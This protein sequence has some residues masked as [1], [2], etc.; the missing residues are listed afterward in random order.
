[1]IAIVK[2]NAGNSTSVKNA[3]E[4]LGFTCTITNDHQALKNA[5]KVIFPGV[6]AA[7]RAMTY[8]KET[9]LD[10]LI[11]A[12]DQPVLGICLGQQLLCA[13]SEEGNVD[14]L[15]IFNAQVKK[16]PPYGSVPHMGW[17]TVEPVQSVELFESDGTRPR[18][19][20]V[21]SYFIR[22]DD[23]KSILCSTNYGGEFASGVQRGHIFGVQFH[24]EK[25]HKF[26]MQLLK[27][28]AEL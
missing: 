8:L 21:H 15:G 3:V 12:L 20:F 5:S 11:V 17:N 16:F 10:K 2:Y 7:S 14:C 22:C 24:P 13:H 28:F 18:F 19:Y 9:G 1:M 6:G 23:R 4:R 25:S 27:N 26:G